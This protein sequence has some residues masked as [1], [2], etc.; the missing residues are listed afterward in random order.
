M[1]EKGKQLADDNDGGQ[2]FFLNL[3][4]G[5]LGDASKEMQKLILLCR[6]VGG[7]MDVVRHDKR[8]GQHYAFISFETEKSASEAHRKSLILLPSLIWK[9][10]RNGNGLEENI[11][12]CLSKDKKKEF[13]GNVPQ[14]AL[15]Q[16]VEEAGLMMMETDRRVIQYTI[17]DGN[18]YHKF[19]E[20]LR[21]NLTTGDLYV[22]AGDLSS[23]VL[24]KLKD[25][26]KQDRWLHIE[27]H[28][29]Q[30]SSNLRAEKQSSN[31]RAEKQSTNL[32]AE[33]QSNNLSAEKQSSNVCWTTTLAMRRDNLYVC[34][35]TG[36]D[37][38][39]F[40]LDDTDPLPKE[41]DAKPSGWKVSYESM[42]N[43]ND[44]DQVKQLLAGTSLG[45]AFAKRAVRRLS[46][47]PAL[48]YDDKNPTGLGLAGLIVLIC[49]SARMERILEAFP[50]KK[51]DVNFGKG[52]LVDPQVLDNI[53]NWGNMS[54]ALIKWK[55]SGYKKE[56]DRRCYVSTPGEALGRV[57]LVQ[58]YGD[59][60]G[61]GVAMVEILAV[62]ANFD[63]VSI[64]V[65]SDRGDKDTIYNQE[66]TGI[67]LLM[68]Q[69]RWYKQEM[70]PL[71]LAV[72]RK[73]IS[74]YEWFSMEVVPAEGAG[75][76]TP[77]KFKWACRKQ[78]GG[79]TEL[80]TRKIIIDSKRQMIVTYLVMSDAI[81]VKVDITLHHGLGADY[82]R[83][84]RNKY[85]A[86]G[87][88][89][90]AARIEGFDDNRII[91]FR[92]SELKAETFASMSN[93]LQR[94]DVWVPRG[95]RLHIE[96]RGLHS[97][98]SNEDVS[99]EDVSEAHALSFY[100]LQNTYNNSFKGPSFPVVSSHNYPFH[101]L[102]SYLFVRFAL[103]PPSP[104]PPVFNGAASSN[105]GRSQPPAGPSSGDNFTLVAVNITWE[106][107]QEKNNKDSVQIR[108]ISKGKIKWII[109]DDP[110]KFTTRIEKLRS[111]VTKSRHLPQDILWGYTGTDLSSTGNHPVLATYCP[112]E[113]HCIKIELQ[114]VE[115]KKQSSTTLAIE[116]QGCL[117]LGFKNQSGV[118]YNIEDKTGNC[119]YGLPPHYNSVSLH[120]GIHYTEIMKA[121]SWG[122]LR[123]QLSTARLGKTFVMNAV[124]T[125]SRYPDIE[126]GDM[127][128]RLALVGLIILVCESAKLNPLCKT[129]EDNWNNGA[130]FTQPMVDYIVNWK[131]MS[132]MLL[133]WRN[134]AYRVWP[135]SLIPKPL[136]KIS[137]P[138]KA[139]HV[140]H[141]VFDD[142]HARARQIDMTY[143]IGDEKMEY[144]T[145][146]EKL[147][148]NLAKHTDHDDVL[149]DDRPGA[150]P[151]LPAR[152][153]RPVMWHIQ[154]QVD[155]ETWT[156]LALQ[157]DNLF[158]CG[159]TSHNKI[160]HD[161]G[162][163]CSG[164][165]P[166]AYNAKTLGWG[167]NVVSMLDD[168]RNEE[169]VRLDKINAMAAVRTLSRYPK[170]EPG[171]NPKQALVRLALMVTWSANL[172]LVHRAVVDG[173]RDG[174]ILDRS[175]GLMGHI[176]NWPL[177][178]K[179]GGRLTWHKDKLLK[180]IGIKGPQ[181][182][183]DVVGLVC[184]ASPIKIDMVWTIKDEIT[185]TKF[186]DDLRKELAN[187]PHRKDLI[188]GD[189]P[190]VHQ[191]LP[192][193]R[194]GL[195]ARLVHIKLEVPDDIRSAI[196]AVKDDDMS[197]V[198]FQN[199]AGDWFEL[200]G[201]HHQPTLLPSE[202]RSRL[203]LRRGCS[204]ADMLDTLENSNLEKV[205]WNPEYDYGREV[206]GYDYITWRKSTGTKLLL[207]KDF[208]MAAVR[209]LSFGD[210]HMEPRLALA[211][212]SIM[213]SEGA[214]MNPLRDAVVQGWN[215]AALTKPLM[216]YIKNWKRM[217]RVLLDRKDDGNSSWPQ[218]L[219]SIGIMDSNRAREVIHLVFN[220]DRARTKQIH[221]TY[222][223]RDEEGYT[224]F[225]EEL[226]SNLA[227]HPDHD[228][229][230][231]DDEPGAYPMLPE[232]GA[233]P[234]MRHIQ[235]QVDEKTSTTLA[236]QDDNM[237]I[238]GFMNQNKIWHDIGSLD[239]QLPE[240]YAAEY[241]NLGTLN[242]GRNEEAVRLG[243]TIATVAVGTLSRY[244][245]KE[246]GDM[247]LRQALVTL[248]LMVTWSANIT[249]VHDAVVD[250][251]RDGMVLDPKLLDY[252]L[253]WPLISSALLDWK[254][255][256]RLTWHQDTG[257]EAIGIKGPECA[258]GV[259]GFVCQASPI[260]IDSEW[261]IQDVEKYIEFI[262]DLRSKLANH[263]HRKDLIRGDQPGVHP[264]LPRHLLL[265]RLVHIKLKVPGEK[266]SVTLAVRDDDMIV[267]GFQNHMGEWFDLGSKYHQPALL[268]S[269]YKSREFL[270][271]GYSYADILNSSNLEEVT[272]LLGKGFAMAAVRELSC[273]EGDMDPRQALAGLSIMV[274]DCA[275]MNPL[276]DAV[277]H[278][279]NEGA[280]F[281]KQLM[282]YIT[283][284]KHISSALLNCKDEGTSTWPRDLESIGIKDKDYA[285]KIIYLVYNDGHAWTKQVAQGKIID[286]QLRLADQIQPV[287]ED[288]A[289][290]H[291]DR[292]QGTHNQI[293]DYSDCQVH[294]RCP[295]VGPGSYDPCTNTDAKLPYTGLGSA[296]IVPAASELS[297]ADHVQTIDSDNYVESYETNSDG[298]DHDHHLQQKPDLDRTSIY[299][300][301]VDSSE[302][303]TLSEEERA[304]DDL[305]SLQA[306]MPSD[307][308]ISPKHRRIKASSSVNQTSPNQSSAKDQITHNAVICAPDFQFLPNDDVPEKFVN[309]KAFLT[310]GM[311]QKGPWQ[312]LKFHQWYMRASKRKFSAI[313]VNIPYT[314][315]LSE[316]RY[317]TLD[318]KDIHDMFRK[319]KLDIN[320]L[321]V[322]CLMQ[323]NDARKL[324]N[325]AAFLDPQCISMNQLNM[326]LRDD[327]PRIKGKKKKD[328]AKILEE[329]RSR[330]RQD[331]AAYIG[332]VFLERQDAKYIMA[333]YHFGDHY[334]S[335][336][337]MPMWSRLVVFDSSDL[338][339][340]SYKDFI[341]VLQIAYRRYVYKGGKHDPASPQEMAVRT[342]FPCHKQGFNTVLCG[343][344]VCEFLRLRKR[345]CTTNPEEEWYARVNHQLTDE[346]ITN[347]IADMCQFIMHEIIHQDGDFYDMGSDL[348]AHPVL[349][350]WDRTNLIS[351]EE[352]E[353]AGNN[354]NS[355]DV[356]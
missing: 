266:T 34:G 227:S 40:E 171:D 61:S 39:W 121:P 41:Y 120:W 42:M 132:K 73:C 208:A 224:T 280:V 203:F 331:V 68:Q 352:I 69:L 48:D 210:D 312:M 239:M 322:W 5:Q 215:G 63:V 342:N 159:F 184:Q 32:S 309:G 27:L 52:V 130:E 275:K 67:G 157:D 294:T 267:I 155:K 306:A 199:D 303:M 125:L 354:A 60:D 237:F 279:W 25:L 162:G 106:S 158:I 278:G 326:K 137:S 14:D 122:E 315:F 70:K 295:G 33:K 344:Y 166:L 180:S 160:W 87:E 81:N 314:A 83:R 54:A 248:A 202:Y 169:A 189:R 232:R 282:D 103:P 256:G 259:V 269:E 98:P 285:L 328:K 179:Y 51:W 57:R 249:P 95:K 151:V 250:G 351:L 16:A 229:V 21:E 292:N 297:L 236:L 231:T 333:P 19:I 183:L 339:L 111:K 283:N 234:V 6:Q 195:P 349:C 18:G 45:K 308:I 299:L 341:E 198:G 133:Y 340:E 257:L 270:D 59:I 99:N 336:M 219:Q 214:K 240:E 12:V 244:P 101:E 22:T 192:R 212:L 209:T 86:H 181:R 251:W 148:S 335:I 43:L 273:W 74:G 146:I 173:W 136:I 153:A 113:W 222:I 182:A 66:D 228:D 211:G 88:I 75:D 168:G 96:M 90:I 242:V 201:D 313:I 71:K 281:T 112:L 20:D 127:N 302:E 94:P 77:R 245:K 118:W 107:S 204:Y 296:K 102:P 55:N 277:I 196:L 221:M 124:R 300:A 109:G 233:T 135:Q 80:V 207:G 49:E 325:P 329:I 26:D 139:L 316:D 252:I 337:I 253:D 156:T 1:D 246:P 268:P 353:E 114:A 262:G 150:H 218:D 338:P 165:L 217:S 170:V 53:W 50:P 274:T 330:N 174:M 355:Q 9:L 287:L 2:P 126:D 154:L 145:F 164:Q 10:N 13:I 264:V 343:Y 265:A 346:D 243:K 206:E 356:V 36:K 82:W 117:G 223:I 161:I 260:K 85:T 327:D 298:A 305:A 188:N 93:L 91:L 152:G 276:R 3:D 289:T 64:K 35:F 38:E 23:P 138:K 186:I 310:D 4:G 105:G 134:L 163:E 144:T 324:N 108:E 8:N 11:S 187:H 110:R 29:K 167:V 141:L 321:T 348:A 350:Q 226:L 17:G 30:Q 97:I 230:L 119:N 191:V 31:L 46:R 311:L 216:D 261:T 284:W 258:L 37:G 47:Y 194:R 92:K 142:G 254:D 307:N 24:P 76:N 193:Q 263:P 89:E 56:W 220:D 247:D 7:V 143:I 345:Y 72:R 149:T 176:R 291:A 288:I 131:S 128:P 78:D 147:R 62:S 235:L 255:R 100:Y 190:G 58:N 200:G 175:R 172:R 44:R 213:V 347:I 272:K 115:R 104:A 185:Y 334:I 318:F 320:L 15:K 241:L 123:S 129:F 238:C 301:G 84:E 317:I 323:Y 290:K 116:G 319:D 293:I 286:N 28:A 197:V 271:W 304:I 79:P 178:W 205:I 177:N 332:K 225:I 140:V 65:T